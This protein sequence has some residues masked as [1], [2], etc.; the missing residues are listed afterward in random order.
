MMIGCTNHHTHLVGLR[1]S[2][3]ARGMREIRLKRYTG[4]PTMFSYLENF[5]NRLRKRIG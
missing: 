5:A 3:N 1:N 4:A 2:Q